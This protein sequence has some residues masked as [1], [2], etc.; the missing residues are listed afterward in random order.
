MS[1]LDAGLEGK[2]AVVTGGANG[3]GFAVARLLAAH[4]AS[5]WIFDLERENPQNA[6][7]QI[8]ARAFHAQKLA[9]VLTSV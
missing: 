5:V 2:L 4:R 6:A 3:I 8:G 7:Q 9:H 1:G